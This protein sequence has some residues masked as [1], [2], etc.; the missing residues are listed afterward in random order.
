MASPVDLS[1]KRF[2]HLTA[3]RRVRTGTS[4]WMCRC[5]CGRV[6]RVRARLLKEAAITAC[7]LCA[8]RAM[9]EA[10]T[11]GRALPQDNNGIGQSSGK[12]KPATP[13][14]VRRLAARPHLVPVFRRELERRLEAL[15]R[16]GIREPITDQYK[17]E[18]VDVL[19][20]ESEVGRR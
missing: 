11:R 9:L 12:T 14:W 8:G 18:L 16:C 10:W 2:G 15:R 1:G 13:A 5:A 4:E 19:I 6:R 7:Y 17:D 3:E 20:R